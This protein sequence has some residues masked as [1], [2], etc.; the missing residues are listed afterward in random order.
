MTCGRKRLTEMWGR[1][2]C[3]VTKETGGNGPERTGGGRGNTIP[4]NSKCNSTKKVLI[5]KP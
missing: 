5:L 3:L 2:V 1:G 4:K